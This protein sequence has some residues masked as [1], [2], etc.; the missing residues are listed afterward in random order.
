MQ[1]VERSTVGKKVYLS[2]DVRDKKVL[3]LLKIEFNSYIVF[4]Y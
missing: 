4:Y 3:P 2:K 1:T